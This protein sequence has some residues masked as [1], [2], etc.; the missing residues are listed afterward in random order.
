MDL[1]TQREFRELL[2]THTG[3]CIS[4]YMPAHRYGGETQQDP[5]RFRNLMNETDKL[6]KK[7]GVRAT[8]AESLLEPLRRL[9]ADGMFWR[10][11]G[12]ALALFRSVEHFHCFRLPLKV[13]E[14]ALVQDH[15]HVTPL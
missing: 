7:Q 2:A 5:I 1:F 13:E 11:Q 6:L 10:H 15:F 4:I 8:Q 12:D 9:Q 3:P 14:M